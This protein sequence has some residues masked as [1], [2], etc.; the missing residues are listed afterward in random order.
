MESQMTIP[1]I[2]EAVKAGTLE[3]R[4]AF[5]DILAVFVEVDMAAFGSRVDRLVFEHAMKKRRELIEEKQKSRLIF[6]DIKTAPKIPGRQ[7]LT[8]G[9]IPG[10][11]GGFEPDRFCFSVSA[12]AGWGADHEWSSQA[13]NPF[14]RRFVP[15]TWA[16]LPEN[17]GVTK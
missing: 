1:Q 13:E 9:K 16:E 4:D 8:F 2:L 3:P 11:A 12:F 14:G 6:L 5:F 7:I 15:M 10:G 17:D